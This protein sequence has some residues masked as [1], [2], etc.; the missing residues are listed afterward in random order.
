MEECGI[1]A[2]KAKLITP[3]PC[4]HK[5]CF[6]CYK[7]LSKCP[8]CKVRYTI[9]NLASKKIIKV[10]I[11]KGYERDDSSSEEEDEEETDK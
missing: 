5:I 3:K 10:E 4:S 7:M 6:T 1:C 2:T 9:G 8:F 11:D